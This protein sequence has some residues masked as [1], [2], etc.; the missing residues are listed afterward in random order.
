M[1]QTQA[2]Y[3]NIYRF[4]FLIYATLI[5]FAIVFYKERI[6]FGDAAFHLFFLLK[7][8]WFEIQAFRFGT[9]LTQILPLLASKL[10]V[11]LAGVMLTYSLSYILNNFICYILCG[12]VFNNHKYAV[13][14]LLCNTIM[15]SDAFYSVQSEIMQGVPMVVA[16]LAYTTGR[17][18]SEMNW[19]KY[20]LYAAG[21][22]TIAFIHPLAVFP[23][24]FA[25]GYHLLRKDSIADRKLLLWSIAFYVIVMV[26]KRT[27][28][29]AGYDNNAESGTG[30]FTSWFPNY[31]ATP[32]ALKFYRYCI[33]KYYWL[34]LLSLVI[35]GVYIYRKQWQML[36]FFLL[37]VVGYMTVV[38]VTHAD[39]VMTDTYAE[40]MYIVMSFMVALPFVYDVLPLFKR[41]YFAVSAVAVIAVLGVVRIYNARETNVNRL[42]WE[43]QFMKENNYGKV[44]ISNKKVPMETVV[45]TWPTP[46][47]FWMLSMTEHGSA[48]SILVTED[49]NK[50]TTFVDGNSKSLITEWEI[51]PYNQLPKEYFKFEDTVNQYTIIQ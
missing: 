4:G 34:P 21:L 28:F 37:F 23:V 16:V 35:T 38:N 5:C 50:Q 39:A 22:V 24:L 13:V 31:F 2:V 48:A 10:H 1:Q 8:G 17:K 6:I 14:L 3:K 45:F 41:E 19:W 20:L 42:A 15:I 30:N 44:L 40:T 12:S 27:L 11:S 25:F 51:I 26:V 9:A 18:M 7:N 33:D 43:R 46:Y 29:V 49:I 36:V 47:E 32:T